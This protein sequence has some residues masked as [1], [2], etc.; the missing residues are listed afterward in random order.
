MTN[1]SKPPRP[2]R[3]DPD[4]LSSN[5]GIRPADVRSAVEQERHNQEMAKVKKREAEGIVQPTPNQLILM[6]AMKTG[7][8][9]DRFIDEI[10]RAQIQGLILGGLA[11]RAEEPL[12]AALGAAQETVSMYSLT[13]RGSHTLKAALAAPGE[14]EQLIAEA[15]RWDPGGSI[16]IDGDYSKRVIELYAILLRRFI[17]RG[18]VTD[19]HIQAQFA[20]DRFGT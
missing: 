17:L 18:N 2:R 10:T 8:I 19:L 4:T 5:L 15:E 12:P 20:L 7:P 14:I 3:L 13:E 9:H 1:S 6:S 16:D 11:K